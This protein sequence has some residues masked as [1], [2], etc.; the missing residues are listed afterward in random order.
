MLHFIQGADL[1]LYP[2]L[3]ESMFRDRADQ[4]RTRLGWDV[5]VDADGHERDDY[6]ALNPL[7]VVW[8]ARDG[9]HQGS[10]RFMPTIR[11]TMLNDHFQHLLGRPLQDPMIWECSRFCLGR[12]AAPNV[13]AA[14]MLGGG[15]VIRH[16]RLSHFVGVFDARMVRIYRR[17]GWS[18]QVLNSAGDG[19]DR[20]SLGLWSR[21]GENRDRIAAK[22]SVSQSLC[23]AWFLA[24]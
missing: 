20:I 21:D 18:P 14:L 7:Y 16:H 5:H 10:M 22:A 24:T 9:K 1:P 23:K 19:R 13:A 8:T 3:A 2:V 15:E 17:I 6:D 11:R 4:F 12:G